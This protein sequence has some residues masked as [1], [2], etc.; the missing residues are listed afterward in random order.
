MGLVQTCNLCAGRGI[1]DL[2]QI[3]IRC[4]NRGSPNSIIRK[5]GRN[6]HIKR[7]NIRHEGKADATK[8]KKTPLRQRHHIGKEDATK[9]KAPRRQRIYA[10]KAKR[11]QRR[12]AVNAIRWT[13]THD[14]CHRGPRMPSNKDILC[15]QP[16]ISRVTGGVD[17]RVVLNHSPFPQT[18]LFF[19]ETER[20]SAEVA[21]KEGMSLFNGVR[22]THATSGDL[23][24]EVI[25][26]G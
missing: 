23:A 17:S 4:S 5:I 13:K 9:A 10:T 15:I 18:R 2:N 7:K 21:P 25:I 24:N 22:A 14:I 16:G 8:A 12:E 11:L 19:D 6:N 3:E 26:K 20:G 1:C